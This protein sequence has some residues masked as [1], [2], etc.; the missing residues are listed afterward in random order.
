MRTLLI[1]YD[2]SDTSSEAY[3]AVAVAIKANVTAWWHHL[4]ST[5]IV[6]TRLDP[7][8]FRDALRSALPRASEVFVA[9]ITDSATAWRGFSDSGTNWLERNLG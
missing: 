6:R 3:E 8:A 1:G 4:D 2:L 9:D 5:W 7:V